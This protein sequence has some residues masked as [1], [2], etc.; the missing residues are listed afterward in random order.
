LRNYLWR[1]HRTLGESYAAAWTAKHS[2]QALKA[3]P[4]D[5]WPV[6]PSA[7]AEA[8]VWRTAADPLNADSAHR[9]DSADYSRLGIKVEPGTRDAPGGGEAHLLAAAAKLEDYGPNH[10]K[11]TMAAAATATAAVHENNNFSLVSEMMIKKEVAA[12][13]DYYGGGAGPLSPPPSSRLAAEPRLKSRPATDREIRGGR[14][15]SRYRSTSRDKSPA[16]SYSY[17]RSREGSLDRNRYRSSSREGSRE[18]YR[19]RSYEGSL[20][21]AY[22]PRSRDISPERDRYRDE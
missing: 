19:R 22:R 8:S 21:D 5:G 14:S 11:G 20:A 18:A 13:G 16:A 17:A 9:R 7:A 3:E 2:E 6:P 4:P 15:S 12:S 1:C 10:R